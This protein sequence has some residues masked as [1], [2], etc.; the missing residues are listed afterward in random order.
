MVD[1]YQA[2]HV[3]KLDLHYLAAG[4]ARIVAHMYNIGKIEKCGVDIDYE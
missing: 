3:L 4:A 2:R 1:R